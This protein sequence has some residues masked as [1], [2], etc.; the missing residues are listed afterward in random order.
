[1]EPRQKSPRRRVPIDW[2][3]LEV[4]LTWHSDESEYFLNLRGRS[5]H[6]PT[7]NAHRG[8]PRLDGIVRNMSRKANVPENVPAT[9]ENQAKTTLRHP[10]AK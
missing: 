6:R 7:T 3:G 4:A 2:H 9:G 5:A 8:S 1:M 10:T